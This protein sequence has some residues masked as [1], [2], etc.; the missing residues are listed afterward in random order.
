MSEANKQVL[1]RWFDEVWNKRLSATIDEL[2]A[3]D[4]IAHGLSEESGATVQG[5]K[6][7]KVFHQQFVNAFPDI[8]VTVD[9][10]IGEGDMVAAR[11][12]VSGTH[13]GD[14]LGY[15][16]SQSPVDFKVMVFTRI[17]NGQI[18][19]AWN[20]IDFVRMYRQTGRM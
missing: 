4:G 11:C 15:P 1:R 20:T 14:A 19:E 16:A 8:A 3:A 18:A 7:F 13:Q 17:K 10:I 12:S 5:P 2:F 9:D 6:D